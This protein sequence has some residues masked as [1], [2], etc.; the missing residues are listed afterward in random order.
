[1]LGAGQ[2]M[3]STDGGCGCPARMNGAGRRGWAG[4]ELQKCGEKLHGAAQKFCSLCNCGRKLAHAIRIQICSTSA[5]RVQ[6]EDWR[7]LDDLGGRCVSSPR[8]TPDNKVFS[9]EEFN[10]RLAEIQCNKKSLFLF[11]LLYFSFSLCLSLLV[12]GSQGIGLC[13]R[14][15]TWPVGGSRSAIRSPPG[16]WC[17][18]VKWGPDTA[19]AGQTRNLG[20]FSLGSA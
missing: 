20:V 2:L 18:G 15:C 1:M 6:H 12:N 17:P 9:R 19:G 7:T 3:V 13:N 11:S 8:P 5:A 4:G 16:R 10:R 14:R